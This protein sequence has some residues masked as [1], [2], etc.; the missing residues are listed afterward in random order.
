MQ[1]N[2][3]LS[4]LLKDSTWSMISTF[5][6]KISF[7]IVGI[8]VA[9]I[10][11]AEKFAIFAIIQSV[12]VMLANVFSQSI[13]TATSKHI[14]EYIEFDKNKVGAGIVATLIF[15]MLFASTICLCANFFPNEFSIYL[16]FHEDYL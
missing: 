1:N 16:L 7:V 12:V 3:I 15:S 10:L 6:N 14:A 4:R 5:A 9:R 2:S 13:T 11:G 8:I